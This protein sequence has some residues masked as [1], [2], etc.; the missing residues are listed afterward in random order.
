MEAC[1]AGSSQW[2]V[3]HWDMTDGK[4]VAELRK[5]DLIELFQLIGW[6]RSFWAK[7]VP[8]DVDTSLASSLVGN[9][10]NGFV[11]VA[12][13]SAMCAAAGFQKD[14]VDS[15]PELNAISDSEDEYLDADDGQ[16]GYGPG[17][18]G[19]DAS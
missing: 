11:M 7:P 6:H 19:S 17:G 15:N 9:A 16:D 2:F 3:R 10:F 18:S 1:L 8:K 5:L 13:L 4:S 14:L 12:T